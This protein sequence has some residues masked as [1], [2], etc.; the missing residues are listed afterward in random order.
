MPESPLPKVLP[1][2]SSQDGTQLSYANQL[3]M[4]LRWAWRI[5]W[6]GKAII[7]GCLALALIPTILLLQ[8]AVPRYTASTNI[9]IEAPEAENALS[10]RFAPWMRMT[11][12][13]IRT[14][15]RIA[16]SSVLAKRVIKDL[17]LD[18]YPE[19]NP[20]LRKDRPITAYLSWLNPIRW[21][22]ALANLGEQK[23]PEDLSPAGIARQELT[24]ADRIERAVL[25]AFQQ[26][27]QVQNERQSHVLVISFT[28]EN[29]AMAAEIANAVAD[30]YV[31]DRLEASLED[32]RKVTQWLASRLESLRQDVITAEEA[33]ETYRTTHNLR[34]QGDRQSTVIDQQ[35]SE[36]NSRLVIARAELS[37]NE[38]RQEQ[39]HALRR[40][41]GSLDSTSETLKSQLI[42]NLRQQETELMR[43]LSEASNRYGPRHP[44]MVG[45]NADLGQLRARIAREIDKIGTSVDNDVALSRASVRSL[46]QSLSNLRG[47]SDVAGEAAVR[48]RE[49]EREAEASRDIYEAF[50]TRFKRGT[51]QDEIQRAN[52]RVISPAL[53]PSAPSY[54]RKPVTLSAVTFMAL[55]FGIALVFVLDRLDNM[56]RSSDEAEEL[57]GLPTIAL[58]PKYQ[59]QVKSLLTDA[60]EHPR[61]HLADA[62]RSLRIALDLKPPARQAPGARII[63][64]TSSTPKEG[65]TFAALSLAAMC[66]KTGER[67]LLIDGDVHRPKLHTLVDCPNEQGFVQL[68]TGS[69]DVQDLV[70]RDVVPGLD[71]LPAGQLEHVADLISES[72]GAK[73]LDMLSPLYDRIIIDTA[74]VLAVAD[75]RVL[76]RL[77]DHLI[78]LIRWNATP[79][80]A[81][82]NGIK[83]L[84]EAGVPLHG[85]VLS[86]VNQR[87]HARYAYGDYGHYYGRY[88]SY[89]GD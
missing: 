68:L 87:K 28:S 2:A 73:V 45:L 37:E 5:A 36:L 82:R 64:I 16:R 26:R 69:A 85:T 9:V 56:I 61:S 18:T 49:L 25:G 57:T 47:E 31:L 55:T 77:A 12:S 67:V 19:F 15:V 11:D 4:T 29:A 3:Q 38:A 78:Y 6:R 34:K 42:Q 7:L 58:I 80:D 41:G 75:V 33:A 88:R 54:P 81:V 66:T 65:K 83:L 71:F 43:E 46:E 13:V 1:P 39:I 32:T 27:L 24:K 63:V 89:Y 74:P 51:E 52:A 84:R 70:L 72:R 48:L 59:G 53:T 8:Q 23:E 50:L 79:R 86:Q 76:G 44:T 35:I 17:R 60:I 40:A 10:E 20:S 22:T 30:A 21:L 62:V 14:E